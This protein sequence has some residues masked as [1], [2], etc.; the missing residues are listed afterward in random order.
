M[1]GDSI[2]NFA[3][4]IIA[5]LSL[6]LFGCEQE[7]LN[8]NNKRATY[9]GQE[10]KELQENQTINELEINITVNE[11]I[12]ED[13]GIIGYVV[14]RE[15]DRILVVDLKKEDRSTWVS[16]VP[17]EIEIGQQIKVWYKGVVFFSS[18]AQAELGKYKIITEI[19]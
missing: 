1:G 19:Q 4:P 12:K 2:K 8:E 6:G 14:E 5:V 10:A 17:E 13:T 11:E 7:Q 9:E 3:L 16:N 18:P 15:G